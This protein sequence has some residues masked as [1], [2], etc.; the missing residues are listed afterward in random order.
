MTPV[1]VTDTLLHTLVAGSHAEGVTAMDVTATVV[2][3]GRILLIAEPGADFIDGT[4]QPPTRP[5][6]PGETLDDALAKTLAT[7]GLDLDQIAGYLGHHDRDDTHGTDEIVRVFC[8][9]CT[10]THPD[11]ICRSA[12]ISHWWADLEDL[13]DLPPPP[14]SYW[15]STAAPT[16]PV[17]HPERDEPPLAEPLRTSARGLRATEAGTELLIGHGSWLHRSDFR[18]RFVHLDTSLTDDTD[19]ASID[20][21]AAITALD[22]GDLACSGGEGRM[23]RLAASLIDGIPINLGD[24][25]TGL[26]SRNLNR[27]G[28]AV[29]HL[30]DRRQPAPHS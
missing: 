14:E 5:V 17:S 12:R 4:W 30:N 15:A 18:D 24:A 26:D 7:V 6:L 25:L 9:A 16:M 27:V 8:F 3:D 29:R 19:I 2:C 10:V 23:L 22:T 1:A 11:S 13:P 28:Q 20:W 21:P